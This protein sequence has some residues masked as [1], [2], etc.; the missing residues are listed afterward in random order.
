MYGRTVMICTQCT[1]MCCVLSVRR[2]LE[3]RVSRVYEMRPSA[4]PRSQAQTR[5][6]V[7][8]DLP[9]FRFVDRSWDS[10]SVRPM[11]GRHDPSR[12]SQQ[13]ETRA[14]TQPKE[15][16]SQPMDQM[17]GCCTCNLP[18]ASGIG[19]WDRAGWAGL[20]RIARILRVVV[21]VM[22]QVTVQVCVCLAVGTEGGTYVGPRPSRL[23]SSN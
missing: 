20:G 9:P 22:L 6:P 1:A 16:A 4:R 12:P 18:A 10:P 23:R 5:F 17:N 13:R 3:F 19:G 14:C 11:T 2:L 7:L 8:P 21:Q 15:S